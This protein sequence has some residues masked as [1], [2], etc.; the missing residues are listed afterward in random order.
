MNTFD[1][2]ISQIQGFLYE[3]QYFVLMGL[4]VIGITILL[5]YIHNHTLMSR[6]P[7]IV[8][9]D[10]DETLGSFVQLGVVKD[11]YQRYENRPNLTQDEFNE[12]AD[13]FPEFIR[14]GILDIL[15][16][17]V[18]QRKSK[19]C[20][21][22]MIYTNNQGPREWA[23]MISNYFA[24]KVGS[25][26][27]DQIIAAFMV[28]GRRVEFGRTSHEKSFSDFIRCTKLP[29]STEI[30]FFDDVEHPQ[31]E[32]KNVYYVNIKPYHNKLPI[33]EC[34]ARLY[35]RQV[36]RQVE[37][38]ETAQNVYAPNILNGIPKTQEE[39]EVDVVIGKYMVQHMRDFFAHHRKTQSSTRR[40]K[41][42]AESRRSM[43]RKTTDLTRR[44]S[45]N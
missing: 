35:P 13:K 23:N 34:I 5:Y 39:Q 28:N 16:Y 31:M 36:S 37:C 1:T 6:P 2:L 45:A 24:Y 44:H 38:L 11:I 14:P 43:S 32:H 42:Q 7:I 17:V 12:L 29:Q 18:K 26:V 4:C 25:P 8:V 40:R 15:T 27:F 22:V 19:R 3:N 41:R 10:L 9:F 30:C 21:G 20:D 33:D